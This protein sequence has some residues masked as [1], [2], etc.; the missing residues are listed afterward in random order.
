MALRAVGADLCDDG[1]RDVFGR[2]AGRRLPSTVMRMRFGFFCHSV[3][4]ISTCATSEA[5][6]AK[7]IGAEGAVG[8][9]VAVAAHGQ[10]ARQRQPLF[11]P[12]HMH[13]A[14]ARIA[15]AEQRDAVI[16]RIGLEIGHHGGDLRI[17]D[18]GGAAVGG[19]V[20]VGDGESEPRLGHLAPARLQLA[21]G[22]ERAFMHVMAVDPEQR[23]AVLAAGDLVR[24]PQLVDQGLR[25][26]HG[27]RV[28]LPQH[29]AG[30]SR[31]GNNVC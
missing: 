3:C 6:I 11:G 17:G 25:L 22:V 19:D 7:S 2:D 30:L 10:Q 31:V 12:D 13:D 8:G 24:R 27:R 1:K 28:A 16:R 23:G 18:A 21:E 14:L 9:G 15:Q 20:M 29:P 5:P 26:A 4:V